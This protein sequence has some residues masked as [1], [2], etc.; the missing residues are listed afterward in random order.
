M[1]LVRDNHKE[2]EGRADVVVQR[3]KNELSDFRSVA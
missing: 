1:V 2:T 3:L